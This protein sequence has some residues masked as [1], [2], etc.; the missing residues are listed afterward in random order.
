MDHFDKY[1]FK[2]DNPNEFGI[3]LKKF[4]KNEILDE[5]HLSNLLSHS[6]R[7]SEDILPSVSQSI[8]SVIEN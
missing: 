4:K 1:K 5:I 8:D 3:D 7:I 2:S 6:I